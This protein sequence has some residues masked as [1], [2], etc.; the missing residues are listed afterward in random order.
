[1]MSLLKKVC[2]KTP[3]CDCYGTVRVNGV[4]EIHYC[5]GNIAR[6][7]DKEMNLVTLTRFISY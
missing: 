7:D 5:N 6:V 4:T 2:K 1:M 3:D